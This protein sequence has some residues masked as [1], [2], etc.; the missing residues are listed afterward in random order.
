MGLC[1][2]HLSQAFE[3]CDSFHQQL[4]THCEDEEGVLSGRIAFLTA[5]LTKTKQRPLEQLLRANGVD[6]EPGSKTGQLRC[7]LKKHIK[8]LQKL[9]QN[10]LRLKLGLKHD[11]MNVKSV[12]ISFIL[13]GLRFHLHG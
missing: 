5:I 2:S 1:S 10:L 8:S 6:F 4:N 13:T 3:G 11:Y 9:S 7:T 12:I